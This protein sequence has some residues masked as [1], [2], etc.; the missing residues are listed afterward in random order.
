MR[1][2]A[3][4]ALSLLPASAALAQYEPQGRVLSERI[5]VERRG[6]PPIVVQQRARNVCV[7]WCSAD[8]NPCDPPSFKAADGRCTNDNY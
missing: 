5:V 1:L 8:Y 6:G 2:A 7:P 3:I 4:V